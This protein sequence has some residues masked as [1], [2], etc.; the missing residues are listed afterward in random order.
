MGKIAS[1]KWPNVLFGSL[2]IEPSRNGIYK[3]KEF[4][5]EGVKI[6]NMGELFA[7]DTISDQEMNR[8]KLNESELSR[9]GLNDGDLLFGRRSLVESG[10]GK[11]SIVENLPESTTFESSIIRVKINQMQNNPRFYYYWFKS[12]YGRAKIKSI[13]TGTNVKGITGNNLK[14]INVIHPEFRVQTSIVA[15]LTAYDYLIENNRHRIQLLEEAARLLYREWFVRLRFPGHEHTR[16]IDGLPEGWE[17]KTAYDVMEICSGGTPRTDNQEYWNGEIPFFTPK[18]VKDQI[19]SWITE[20]NITDIG[21]RNCNSKLY[22]K[23]T[24][25]ITARGTV[26]K[27]CFAQTDMAMNQSCYALISRKPLNQ[28]FLFFALKDSISQFK[29]RAV[30]AVFD[31]IVIDTFKM[32]PFTMPAKHLIEEFTLQVTP[33]IRQIDNLIQQNHKLKEA[34]DLLLPRLMNGVIP[35]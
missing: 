7:Y 20:K 24:I 9:F 8:L 33:N 29:S 13:V 3:S 34:R 6:V 4:H 18:D 21:L 2:Y 31:A 30:G 19:Y 28:Y 16:M 14:N 5:G 27:I 17:E 35:V 12:H 11:C 1:V 15:I 25:F 22:P 23:D 26:G 32:I 10:A